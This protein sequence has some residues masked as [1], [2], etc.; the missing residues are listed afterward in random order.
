M[1]E[2]GTEINFYRFLRDLRMKNKRNDLVKIINYLVSQNI[3][4][5]F[6]KEDKRIDDNLLVAKNTIINPIIES[7]IDDVFPVFGEQEL[8][9]RESARFIQDVNQEGLIEVLKLSS[10]FS[11]HS[12]A[13]DILFIE[14]FKTY[15]EN[16]SISGSY[17]LETLLDHRYF[18]FEKLT[19]AQFLNIVLNLVNLNYLDDPKE[20]NIKNLTADAKKLDDLMGLAPE[21]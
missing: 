12:L 8:F 9:I 17:F 15:L 4:V 3:E 2:L 16:D 13:R 11:R 21:R 5:N 18:D 6:Y 20:F 10:K 14:I 19:T 1:I 7:Q